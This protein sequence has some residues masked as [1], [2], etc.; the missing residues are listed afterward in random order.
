MGGCLNVGPVRRI[1]QQESPLLLTEGA[2]RSPESGAVCRILPCVRRQQEEIEEI[3]LLAQDLESSAILR[4]LRSQAVIAGSAGCLEGRSGRSRE[5]VV[6]QV[7]VEV[8][9]DID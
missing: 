8:A 9:P 6:P 7:G 4:E 3:D 1:D 5:V 2:R